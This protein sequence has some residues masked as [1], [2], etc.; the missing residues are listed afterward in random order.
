MGKSMAAWVVY[1]VVME[2]FVAY[3][4]GRTLPAGAEFL[5]VFQIAGTVGIL[6]FAGAVAPQAIFDG[7]VYGLLSA[8]AF[9]WLWPAAV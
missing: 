3:L 7:V 1:I 5:Q 2:V 8:A 6:A 9:G 4:T